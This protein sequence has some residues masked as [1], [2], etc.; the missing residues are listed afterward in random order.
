L[1]KASKRRRRPAAI[2]TLVF[3]TTIPDAEIAC[4]Q[5]LAA[6]AGGYASPGQFDILLD[7]RDLLF[8][9]AKHRRDEG[10]LAVC[11]AANVALR[12]VRAS[13]DG[14]RFAPLDDDQL[15][16]FRILVDV[17]HDFWG[18]QSGALYQEAYLALRDW[19]AKQDKQDERERY[20][21]RSEATRTDETG[22]VCS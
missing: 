15:N 2:P 19:R 9:A 5:A 17:S 6:F 3:R 7:T 16:A 8:V 1:K 21:N 10:M 13:W 11:T 14:E 22:L 18:R 12:D 20:E 4:L